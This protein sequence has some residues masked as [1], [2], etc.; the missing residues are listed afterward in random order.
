VIELGDGGGAGNLVVC[1]VVMMHINENVLNAEKTAID[2]RKIDLVA[3][4][5]G[6]FYCRAHGDALFEIVKPMTSIGIGVDQIPFAIRNSKILTGNHLGQLGNA[7][8]LPDETSVNEY[9]LLELSDLFI[10]YEKDQARLE[11]LLHQ[12]AAQL[13][14]QGKVEEAWK[15]LL[16]FNG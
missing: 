5:G 16:A 6:N 15:T 8:H 10:Q 1:E 11:E 3:R 7:E 9:K 2:Q 4:M 13:L 14:N 12:Q